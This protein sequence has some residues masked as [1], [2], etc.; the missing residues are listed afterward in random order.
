MIPIF[1]DTFFIMEKTNKIV[2]LDL[3]DTLLK[4]D[5]L[6]E[7]DL[8][9]F[10]LYKEVHAELE[11]L[12]QV[13]TLGILSLGTIAFQKKKLS[14]TNITS[15]FLEEHTH[16]VEFKR[17]DVFAEILSKYKGK[18]KVF[19]VEDR[20]DALREAKKADPTITVIWMKRGRYA[21]S[22]KS[23]IDFKPDYTI[24]SLAELLPLVTAE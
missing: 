22:Q 8:K 23:H 9:H 7:S 17:S 19:F 4:T 21:D 10:E 24:S 2:L 6:I 14:E 13:A 16:I 15:Y 12:S 20:L 1:T 5:K 11:M 3:D 18:G